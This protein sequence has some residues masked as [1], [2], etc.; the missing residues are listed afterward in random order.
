MKSFRSNFKLEGTVELPA[1]SNTRVMMMPLIIGEPNSIPD[2]LNHYVN[3]LVKL[4]NF[5]LPSHKDQIGYITIDEKTVEAGKTH[6]RPGLHVDGVYNG[7]V[8]S[9]GGGGWGAVGSGML[10]VSNIE[11]CKAYKQWFNGTIGNDGECDSMVDQLKES[12][13]EIFKPNHVYWLCGLCVHESLPMKETADRQFV[14]LSL[15]S[16]APWFEGYTENPLGIRPSGQI[17]KRRS[18]MDYV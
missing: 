17:L 8:G 9:W 12:G 2:F 15:P 3:C 13:A 14:R 18:Y 16:C 4:F 11:G 6:R 10:T 7:N 1:F 5:A